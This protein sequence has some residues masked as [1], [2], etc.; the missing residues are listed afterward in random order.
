MLSLAQL[1]PETP[2][3]GCAKIPKKHQHQEIT[4]DD[5]L[6]TVRTILNRLDNIHRLIQR[7]Q[8]RRRIKKELSAM[9]WVLVGALLGLILFRSCGIG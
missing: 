3:N 1:A 8:Q 4:M 6:P 5:F 7:R 2:E 9:G